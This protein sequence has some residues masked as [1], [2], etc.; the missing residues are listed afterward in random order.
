MSL[1]LQLLTVFPILLMIIRSQFF[2]L[3]TGESWPSTPK[4]LAFNVLLVGI[5]YVVAAL[6]INVANVIRFVG[7]IA[8][9]VLIFILPVYID[10]RACLEEGTLT[11][12]RALVH[13]TVILVGTLFFI[14]QFVPSLA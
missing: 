9:I 5:T 11:P 6:D 12:L 1:L 7:A 8:G 2:T 3:T 13:T 14:V 10:V 4:V